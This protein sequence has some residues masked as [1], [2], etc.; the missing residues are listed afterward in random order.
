MSW[1]SN[2]KYSLF[3]FNRSSYERSTVLQSLQYFLY[4]IKN[5]ARHKRGID[6]NRFS[7]HEIFI[8]SISM[9][10][11]IIIRNGKIRPIVSKETPRLKIF[12]S[13]LLTSLFWLNR[14][15]WTKKDQYWIVHYNT[16]THLCISVLWNDVKFRI[17][18][19]PTNISW[20][21]IYFACQNIIVNATV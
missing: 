1:N 6:I 19:F 18:Y 7:F 11:F 10:W 13:I 3:N 4:K 15:K 5:N 21:K 14:C 16:N 8:Y 12:R 2:C 20:I 17:Q 9:E